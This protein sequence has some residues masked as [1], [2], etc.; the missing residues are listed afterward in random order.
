MLPGSNHRLPSVEV[1]E[2]AVRLSTITKACW[3]LQV[4]SMP[5][6]KQ[7][8]S[9]FPV[10]GKRQKCAARPENVEWVDVKALT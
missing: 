10:L 7:A 8:T 6:H 3:V 9:P 1:T 4:N 2:L 5:S